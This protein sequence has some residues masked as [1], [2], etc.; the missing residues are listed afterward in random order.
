MKIE[1]IKET[2]ADGEVFY[3]TNIDGRF[4]DK[5]LSYDKDKAYMI[6]QNIVKNKGTY[7][8]KEVLESIEIES[9][10]KE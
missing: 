5:S 10:E 1:F 4:V 2:K 3:F 9:N 8:N 6:Y 7:N